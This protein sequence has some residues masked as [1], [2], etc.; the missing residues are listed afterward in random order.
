M[1]TLVLYTDKNY[2]KNDDKTSKY[3]YVDY[4][5]SPNYIQTLVNK[6]K[7]VHI[8]DT[9][10]MKLGTFLQ[11]KKRRSSDDMFIHKNTENFIKCNYNDI[12]VAPP[13]S[14]SDYYSQD[15]SD[16]TKVAPSDS[17]Y[18][19]TKVVPDINIA[20]ENIFVYFL[21]NVMKLTLVIVLIALVVKH[22]SK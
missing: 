11:N 13:P 12:P 18:D 2:V 17:D 3:V 5:M 16:D 10:N 21:K 14:E 15:D 8:I 1:D 4:N 7:N 9:K 6:Y 19:D 22:I 20:V